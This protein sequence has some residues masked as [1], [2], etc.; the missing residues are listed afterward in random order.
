MNDLM[1][2]EGSKETELLNVEAEVEVLLADKQAD[3]TSPLY[4]VK[5]FEELNLSPELIQGLTRM[6]FYK[7]SK[8]QEKALPLLLSNPP[9]NMIGQSQSGT[10]KT[11]A[12]V[13]TMLS[14]IDYSIKS[15]QAIC[16]APS[17]ELA[18]QIL[19]V[20]QRMGQFTPCTYFLAVKQDAEDGKP[21]SREKVTAQLIVG[22]PGTIA[23]MLQKLRLIDPRHVKVL[24]LDEADNLIAAQGSLSEQTVQIKNIF[25]VQ[26]SRGVQDVP[27]SFSA[28]LFRC[29]FFGSV[30]VFCHQFCADCNGVQFKEGGVDFECE[31][32]GN[33][34][35]VLTS[36]YHVLT[37]GQSI[38]F[39]QRREE[40]DEIA[41]RMIA[42]GHMVSSLH[43]KQEGKE[44][45]Q[46]MNDFRSGKTKV[47]IT[48]N[49]IARGI[50]VLRVSLVINYDLPELKGRIDTETYLH[51]IGRTGRF[52]REGVSVNF[53]HNA[54]SRRDIETIEKELGIAGTDRAM[55]RLPIEDPDAMGKILDDAVKNKQKRSA[56]Q[57]EAAAAAQDNGVKAA[58]NGDSPFF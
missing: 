47:L 50:D 11:A 18:R 4:S 24:V 12:F 23:D 25:W 45:D 43:G 48:T 2:E 40:A 22:T 16:V 56:K 28:V 19:D 55:T 36:I 58:G 51:R 9:K 44:R 1:A 29:P 5:T 27:S 14:R 7:P 52:G 20:A 32:A 54:K 39:V 35:D 6:N 30:W 57:I 41:R 8:I 21:R 3:P 46:V 31:N 33:K 26:G 17:R 34:Y 38:I 15:P 10:G 49:V 42:E 37:I 13:L 53:V